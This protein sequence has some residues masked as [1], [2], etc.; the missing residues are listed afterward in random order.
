MGA[1]KFDLFNVRNDPFFSNAVAIDSGNKFFTF[2]QS[3]RRTA[4]KEI[5]LNPDGSWFISFS[6]TL[7]ISDLFSVDAMP[8]VAN[9]GLFVSEIFSFNLSRNKPTNTQD[10]EPSADFNTDIGILTHLARRLAGVFVFRNNFRI[11]LGKDWLG[12]GDEQTTGGSY[13]SLRP[14]NVLGY[15]SL[16]SQ[17]NPKL[18][19]TSDRESFIE[20]AEFRG[21]MLLMNKFRSFANDALDDLRRAFNDFKKQEVR[22]DQPQINP[23]DAIQDL[24]SIA[25]NAETAST[26]L[27]LNRQS[28]DATFQEIEQSVSELIEQS[29][30]ASDKRRINELATSIGAIRRSYST[31][32]DEASEA[33]NKLKGSEPTIDELHARIGELDEMLAETYESAAIGIAAQGLVHEAHPFV[34]D[35]VKRL[36]SVQRRLKA[37]PNIDQKVYEEL[38]FIRS[39]AVL[40]G[41]RIAYIEPML[42]TFRESKSEISI[43]DFLRDFF[44]LRAERLQ[45]FHINTDFAFVDSDDFTIKINRGRLTQVFDNLT[46]NSEYWLRHFTPKTGEAF[47]RTISIEF[48]KKAIVFSDNGPGVRPAMELV[49][50]DLFTTDKPKGEGQGLGLFITSQLLKAEGCS[51]SLLTERNSNNRRYKFRIDFSNL[52]IK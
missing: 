48:H 33:L 23:T 4:N 10:V 8:H 41:K 50:F 9:P 27:A 36:R 51:I 30:D 26:K 11:R 42:R 24:K 46:R 31:N 37:T 7:G 14:A 16:T 15:V 44:E 21:F 5:K 13:Y 12:L 35:I 38:E 25:K 43:K 52:F 18:M 47:Q 45:E 17:D 3:Y 22:A 20:N 49:L 32:L 1:V 40:I 2:L 39:H 19:E 6:E 29:S 28:T 34:E